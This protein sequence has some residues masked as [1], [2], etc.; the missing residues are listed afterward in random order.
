MIR[1]C[2]S[3]TS[4]SSGNYYSTT[5]SSDIEISKIKPKSDEE[6]I[7]ARAVSGLSI[8]DIQ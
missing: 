1:G 6:D 3:D 5:E 4:E 8:A 2:L 7:A